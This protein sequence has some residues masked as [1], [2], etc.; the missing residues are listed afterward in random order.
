MF[1]SHQIK[2]DLRVLKKKEVHTY[3]TTVFA[4]DYS[5]IVLAANLCTNSNGHSM[6][7]KSF[8]AI[9]LKTEIYH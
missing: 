1:K 4:P 8:S 7:I 2:S 5:T 3:G 9:V 6:Y